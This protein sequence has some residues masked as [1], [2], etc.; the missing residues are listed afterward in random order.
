MWYGGHTERWKT[1]N[2]IPGLDWDIQVLPIGPAGRAGGEIA[3]RAYGI[4]RSS[5]HPEAAWEL[6]KYMVAPENLREQ[7]KLGQLPVR[8]SIAAEWLA[9]PAG[10]SPR[11][12]AAVYQQIPYARPL[13]RSTDYI[14]LSLSIIQPEIDRM[15]R[16][17]ITPEQ[18][19]RNATVAA[20][21]FLKVLGSRKRAGGTEP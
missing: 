5:K 12:R 15:I 1:Y 3:I 4:T 20:N 7:L 13:P 10:G 19:A 9:D 16:G 6:V 8:K 11:N 14:E 18:A 2:A 21:R 17:D